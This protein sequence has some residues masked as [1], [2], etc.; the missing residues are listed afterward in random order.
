MGKTILLGGGKQIIHGNRPTRLE[1][2]P[3]FMGGVTKVLSQVLADGDQPL[4]HD[5]DPYPSP[6]NL[7]GR[8]FRYPSDG[9]TSS[10]STFEMRTAS[11][12]ISPRTPAPPYP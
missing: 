3:E 7:R 1:R 10:S 4:V 5:R 12:G 6:V 8:S 9:L 2:Q 11:G